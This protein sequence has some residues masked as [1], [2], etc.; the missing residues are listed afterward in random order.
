MG[1]DIT[2]VTGG[3]A[4]LEATYAAVRGLAA[5]GKHAAWT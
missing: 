5:L 4:G 1:A 2:G 3:A